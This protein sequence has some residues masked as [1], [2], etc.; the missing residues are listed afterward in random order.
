MAIGSARRYANDKFVRSY[1]RQRSHGCA[2][3]VFGTI[4]RD[5][6][7][8]RWAC[9][10]GPRRIAFCGIS[11][12]FFLRNIGQHSDPRCVYVPPSTGKTF[13]AFRI[14]YARC[15][16]KP[17]LNGQF[18]EN[19]VRMKDW[20]KSS[21]VL[22]PVDWNIVQIYESRE[23]QSTTFIHHYRENI[24][25]FDLNVHQWNTKHPSNRLNRN[26][27]IGKYILI[28]TCNLCFL[29]CRSIPHSACK[30]E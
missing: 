7:F 30:I 26:H 23:E 14:A 21:V 9:D 22:W 19:T 24:W 17:D 12:F 28:L 1:V 6:Q 8:E 11:F 27:S 13:F 29:C 3:I 4:R 16:T 2:F 25:L 10:P 15:G 5:C 18:Y 20:N